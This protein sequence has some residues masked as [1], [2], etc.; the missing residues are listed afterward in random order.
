MFI[1]YFK[2]FKADLPP[3]NNKYHRQYIF[4]KLKLEIR[5]IIINY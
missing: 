5:N 2:I 4:I 1:I 3:Y